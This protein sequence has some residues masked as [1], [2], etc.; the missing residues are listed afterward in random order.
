MYEQI[1]RTLKAQQLE[2]CW[3][4]WDLQ[5]V[6]TC[7][8]GGG[9]RGAQEEEHK[10]SHRGGEISLQMAV[11]RECWFNSSVSFFSTSSLSENPI[12][13]LKNICNIK[14][15]FLPRACEGPGC[16]HG[17]CLQSWRLCSALDRS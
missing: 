9:N 11:Q 13:R 10:Q 15:L 1:I 5:V 3:A 17:L 7:M 16:S 8:G 2:D 12:A 14:C 4:Y 6:P